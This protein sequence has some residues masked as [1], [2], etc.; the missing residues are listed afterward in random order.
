MGEHQ[1]AEQ[2]TAGVAA[3]ALYLVLLA[4]VAVGLYITWQGS[5]NAA[6]GA[7]VVGCSLLVAALARLALP[8]RYA[9]PLFSRG[10]TP[11][12]LAFTVLGAG[13]LGVALMLP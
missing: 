6:R 3:W 9:G 1:K 7:C 12:V 13:V 5:K 11:D 10:K 8:P 2:Q 4:G